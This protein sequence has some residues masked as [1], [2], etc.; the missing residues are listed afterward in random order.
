VTK[1]IWITGASS[2]IG[3]EL[4]LHYARAGNTVAVSAR[5]RQEL[6]TLAAG[7]PGR[8][9]AFPVDVTDAAAMAAC[10]AAIETA[11]GPL[12]LVILNAG[13]YAKAGIDLFDLALFRRHVEINYM[14]VVNGIAAILPRFLARGGG[15]IAV[16][17]SVAGYRG[18]PQAAAY[19]PTKAALINLCES[20]KPDLDR[21]GVRISIVN[22]GF[23]KTPMTEPNTFPMPFLMAPDA[24]ARRIAA[25]LDAGKFEV[26]FPRRFTF[27]LKLARML[28]YGL[29]FRL[30]R[31]LTGR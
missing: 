18:L 7:L 23:V 30:V 2:G 29:Y 31:R 19:G 5:R 22:P 27:M 17:S 16:T 12:D 25:G 10:V 28:P 9:A 26:A 8:I 1:R 3:R 11:L 4:A 20:L 21:R 6:E 24:A 13:I 14:G 15:Q